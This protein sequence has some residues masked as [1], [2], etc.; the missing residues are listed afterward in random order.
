M[1]SALLTRPKP[2]LRRTRH[3]EER[4]QQRGRFAVDRHELGYRLAVLGDDDPVGSH[5]IEEC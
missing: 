5:I 1:N 2:R 3:V 4:A